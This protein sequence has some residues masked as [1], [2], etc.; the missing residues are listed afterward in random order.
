MGASV[1]HSHINLVV[2]ILWPLHFHELLFNLD[3]LSHPYA[4][5]HCY[6]VRQSVFFMVGTGIIV[7]FQQSQS[8]Y[9]NAFLLQ[10]LSERYYAMFGSFHHIH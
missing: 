7:P 5:M 1:K 3:T 6:T 4:F 9:D 10:Y 2:H 8:F